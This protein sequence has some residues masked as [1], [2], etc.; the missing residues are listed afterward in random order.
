MRDALFHL[1]NDIPFAS[2]GGVSG[3]ANLVGVMAAGDGREG[4]RT[5]A[6]FGEE[7]AAGN[8]CVDL[9][10]RCNRGKNRDIGA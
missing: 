4:R 1:Q 2:I 3:G 8:G 7:L 6:A 5:G 9:T 10:T